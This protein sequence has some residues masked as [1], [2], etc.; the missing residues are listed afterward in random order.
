[1][2][3]E[4]VDASRDVG[5]TAVWGVGSGCGVAAQGGVCDEGFSCMLFL[6]CTLRCA[7]ARG[8]RGRQHGPHKSRSSLGHPGAP[9]ALGGGGRS[10]ERRAGNFQYLTREN[11]KPVHAR[12]SREHAASNSGGTALIVSDA[13]DLTA[14]GI[15][16]AVGDG[17]AGGAAIETALAAL[18]AGA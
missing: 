2:V 6:H 18:P 8:V 11:E 9:K 15:A 16:A 14:A 10:G 17:A 4:R 12:A 7:H 1:M 5:A 3:G 13:N